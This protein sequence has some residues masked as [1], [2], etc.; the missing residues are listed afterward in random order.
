MRKIC[1]GIACVALLAAGVLAVI[2]LPGM[3]GE[4]EQDKAMDTQIENKPSLQKTDETSPDAQDKAAEAQWSVRD[5]SKLLKQNDQIIAWITINNTKIDYAI[6]QADNNEYYLHRDDRKKENKNGSIFLDYRNS[7]EFED[8]NSILYGH[9]MKSGRMFA[10]VNLFK[11]KSYFDA[12]KS[13]WL[14]TPDKTYKLEIFAVAVVP[15]TGNA[16]TWAFDSQSAW[17]AYIKQLKKDAKYMRKT[18]LGW[19]ERVVTLST[20][21]YEFKDARTVLLAKIIEK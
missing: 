4:N 21:S 7:A 17:D 6:T 12:H 15:D 14:Y 20:C 3:I 13:G 10:G 11:D 8:P 9:N 19:G 16:Y 2:Y 18:D 5:F 1:I